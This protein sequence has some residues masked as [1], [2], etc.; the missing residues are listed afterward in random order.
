MEQFEDYRDM[1]R[2]A[3]YRYAKN[4]KQSQED[5][6]QEGFLFFLKALDRFEKDKAGFRTYFNRIMNNGF[7]NIIRRE[8]IESTYFLEE[9]PDIE[10]KCAESEYLYILSAFLQLSREAREILKYTCEN[11]FG[12]S[13]M[14]LKRIRGRFTSTGRFSGYKMQILI[15]EIKKWFSEH[16]DTLKTVNCPLNFR[17]ILAKLD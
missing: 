16:K 7:K 11:G 9:F 6:Y 13:K 4:S 1:V 10:Y 3:S 17:E 2:A 14:N 12:A 5:F 8:S 15:K